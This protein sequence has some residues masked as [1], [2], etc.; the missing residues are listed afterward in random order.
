MLEEWGLLSANQPGLDVGDVAGLAAEI[1]LDPL[2]L[3]SFGT[4]QV[5][6]KSLQQAAKGSRLLAKA[7]KPALL[8]QA[9]KA[10]TKLAEQATTVSHLLKPAEKQ[11]ALELAEQASKIGTGLKAA[12]ETGDVVGAVGAVNRLLR[13]TIDVGHKL[14]K[15]G[16]S[17]DA[18]RLERAAGELAQA[19]EKAVPLPELIERYTQA[20]KQGKPAVGVGPAQ[21][22]AEVAQGERGLVG[23]GLP[24]FL[25]GG[26]TPAV[27]FGTGP[28]VAKTL[29]RFY[30]GEKSPLRF[31]RSLFQKHLHG[32]RDANFQ[33]VADK[34]L[35]RVEGQKNLWAEVA[36]VITERYHELMAQYGDVVSHLQRQGDTVGAETVGE[37]LRY[38]AEN[39]QNIEAQLQ[40]AGKL[41]EK[42]PTQQLVHEVL[43]YN[44]EVPAAQIEA[45]ERQ[46]AD[47]L[48]A[49]VKIKDDAYQRALDLGMNGQMLD[50]LFAQHMPRRP[51][52]KRLFKGFAALQRK[53]LGT[54]FPFASPRNQVLREWPEGT[55]FLQQVSRDPLLVGVRES[56]DVLKTKMA[57][58]LGLAGDAAKQF[59]KGSFRDAQIQYVKQRYLQPALNRVGFEFDVDFIERLLDRLA[60]VRATPETVRSAWQ[61]I[62]AGVAGQLEA[63]ALM[64]DEVQLFRDALKAKGI[65]NEDWWAD[66][67]AKAADDPILNGKL[68]KKEIQTLVKHLTG[69]KGRTIQQ[70]RRIYIRHKYLPNILGDMAAVDWN[71]R[72]R[73]LTKYLR[74]LPEKVAERGI[75]DRDALT[76][77][78]DYM[79]HI[80]QTTANLQTIHNFLAHVAK[81][82]ASKGDMTIG[83]L[84]SKLANKGTP[85]SPM[86]DLDLEEG[87]KILAKS[88]RGLTERGLQTF[89][90]DLVK[91][92]PEFRGLEL[93]EL[94]DAVYVP[95]EAVG[96]V[97][98]YLEAMQPKVQHWLLDIYDRMTALFK[99]HVTVPWPAFHTRNMFSG[100]FM[101]IASGLPPGRT[102]KAYGEILLGLYSGNIPYLDEL[103]AV[104]LGVKKGYLADISRVAAER[105][106]EEIPELSFR[107]IFGPLK[108]PPRSYVPFWRVPGA[109][110]KLEKIAAEMGEEVAAKA[111]WPLTAVG[112]KLFGIVEFV[113]RAAPYITLR[114]MG[115]APGEAAAWVRR[116]QYDYTALSG[117][118]RNV[119]RRLVPFWAWIRNNLPYQFELLLRRPGGPTAQAIRTVGKLR[120]ESGEYVP[121]F[122]REG[123][124]IRVGGTPE[125][126]T[127]IRW[128]GLPFEDLA[129]IQFEGARPA[130][131]RTFR[132]FAADLHPLLRFPLE[133]VSGREMFSG[134]EIRYLKPITGPAAT[135][136]A[137]KF[138]YTGGE[139]NLR[140]IDRLLMSVS[141]LS[142]YAISIRGTFQPGKPWRWK[143][144]DLLTGL[145]TGTYDVRKWQMIDLKEALQRQLEATPYVRDLTIPYVPEEYRPRVPEAQQQIEMLRRLS[146]ALRQYMQQRKAAQARQGA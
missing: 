75:F 134:R 100:Y 60:A 72:I 34:L 119:M 52:D 20:I 85:I 111:Q 8:E 90:A 29:E 17:L 128:L 120:E 25:P 47:M 129:R 139:F 67:A 5:A 58:E 40:A 16:R 65:F 27:M 145:K 113:N 124:A 106:G 81:R 140:P 80:A 33:Q 108:A 19:T 142:R 26:K 74:G 62:P 24:W 57:D 141:P 6:S 35:A 10:G 104:D 30:Y 131:G 82:T 126:A 89:L 115:W 66:L 69:R 79:N 98:A 146:K 102:A 125:S 13:Q 137:R 71:A 61:T 21:R 103:R 130:V 48:D 123:S 132:R 143:F 28:R 51:G 94:A 121:S 56:A 41:V 11:A 64:P 144:A 3:L 135:W 133:Q 83:E 43:R 127:F 77:M 122:L 99:T 32:V 92:R 50:D 2:N 68:G 101:N 9:A 55:Y 86:G 15:A 78:F 49:L 109:S 76:D 4:T 96:A 112:E 70:A 45:F 18:V 7:L 53:L 73:E 42:T 93:D 91:K 38:I 97:T 114:R 105:T 110:W 117:F 1:V 44:P 12:S 54:G 116:V 14:T 95:Q 136:V 59:L 37:A 87:L 138:G 46:F 84:W 31:V 39:R 107:A 88:K 23:I 22:I 118:E 36:P 63:A